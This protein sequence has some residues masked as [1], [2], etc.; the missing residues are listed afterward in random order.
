[1]LELHENGYSL[2]VTRVEIPVCKHSAMNVYEGVEIS[3]VLTL[4]VEGGQ[5]VSFMPYLLP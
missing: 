1:L 2:K 4:A 5:V 3:M